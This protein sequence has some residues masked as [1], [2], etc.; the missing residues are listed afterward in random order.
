M[1]NA[2]QMMNN[3]SSLPVPYVAEAAA[4]LQSISWEWGWEDLSASLNFN[5]DR[6]LSMG[7]VVTWCCITG[8]RHCTGEAE[9]MPC[10]SSGAP[11]GYRGC[12]CPPIPEEEA[13]E[14]PRLIPDPGLIPPETWV[15]PD[16][17]K[18]YT[19]QYS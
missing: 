12:C 15:V 13:P 8:R 9:P 17:E 11:E 18:D 3:L 16:P 19:W 7:G 1:R 14:R 2:A 5:I 4:L 10:W 6:P